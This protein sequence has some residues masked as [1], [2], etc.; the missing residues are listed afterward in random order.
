MIRLYNLTD[1]VK[2]Y[3]FVCGNYQNNG[4]H[5][6]QQL[7]DIFGAGKINVIHYKHILT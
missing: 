5:T 3:N 4:N 7:A 1:T 2:H 6:A